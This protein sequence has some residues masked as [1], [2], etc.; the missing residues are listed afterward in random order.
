M[1][2]IATCTACDREFELRMIQE[3][4]TSDGNYFV[5]PIC[6]LEIRNKMHG[7]PDG[8]PFRGEQA[9]ALYYDAL[10]YLH[11]TGQDSQS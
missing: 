3:M 10:A 4:V 8:T 2:D 6:A 11:E 5:C 9:K 7:L 1:S